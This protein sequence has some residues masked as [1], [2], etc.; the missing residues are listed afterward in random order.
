M[1]PSLEAQAFYDPD[2]FVYPFGAHACVVEIDSE[3]GEIEIKRYL[4]V[5][6]PGPV[7]NPM[8]AE[9]QVHGGIVQGIGQ[10][11]WEGAV[12]DAQGQLLSGTFMDYAMP[13][14]RFFPKFETAFTETPS[15]VN[16]LG[17]KGIGE[18]G[19]IAAT[20]AVVNAVID[21]LKPFGV[22]E[23]EMPPHT[24][25]NMERPQKRRGLHTIA[26]AFEYT[27][28]RSVDE[29]IRLLAES[30]GEPK[31]LPEGTVCCL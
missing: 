3:T 25:E 19:T 23:L 14:A 11:L 7:I 16:P 31:C 5:D 9:G 29:A 1:E 13:K 2:N 10:A 20:P 21:A 8:V 18:T 4:A 28:A 12:Y 24:G 17:V 22:K 15:P 27:R 30:G 26:S 6:D